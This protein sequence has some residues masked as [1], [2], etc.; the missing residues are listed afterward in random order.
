MCNGGKETEHIFN[1]LEDATTFY[2]SNPNAAADQFK[3]KR[4]LAGRCHHSRLPPA[5]R[6]A[7]LA[8]AESFA[9]AKKQE[10]IFIDSTEPNTLNHYLITDPALYAM[11]AMAS[12]QKGDTAVKQIG[13]KMQ[14]VTVKDAQHPR[15]KIHHNDIDTISVDVR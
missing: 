12:F 14:I 7:E 15:Y 1:S 13:D 8:A 6:D 10:A 2:K 9:N 4:Y 11:Q 3:I 5:E